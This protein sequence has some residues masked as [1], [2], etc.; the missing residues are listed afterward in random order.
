M[1]SGAK[2]RF[3]DLVEGQ[4]A[5]VSGGK[6]ELHLKKRMS[7]VG[8]HLDF[9]RHDRKESKLD[10]AADAVPPCIPIVRMEMIAYMR[11]YHGPLTPSQPW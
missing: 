1:C 8:V 5:K 6:E 4:Y 2:S 11:P 7:P 3:D 9:S 10:R